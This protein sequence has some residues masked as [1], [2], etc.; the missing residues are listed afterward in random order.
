MYDL[1]L[2]SSDLSPKSIRG[3]PGSIFVPAPE[4]QTIFQLDISESPVKIEKAVSEEIPSLNH[5]AVSPNLLWVV[6]DDGLSIVN[7]T[8]LS[9]QRDVLETEF[10]WSSVVSVASYE[11]FG[12]NLYLLT[13]V[14][15]QIFKI[16]YIE[17]EFSDP[18]SWLVE[19]TDLSEAVDFAIDGEIYILFKDG[20]VLKFLQG[21]KEDFGLL[22]EDF[23]NPI[24]IYTDD[25]LDHIYILD[26]EK[27]GIIVF[28]KEGLYQSQY[29]YDGEDSVW[30]DVRDLWVD[31]ETET[32]YIL[33]GAKV[34][35]ISL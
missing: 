21:E 31:S 16:S 27:K 35:R 13:P 10:A 30:E 33:A 6:E 19:E 7:R 3:A 20:A 32:I 29:L 11:A 5:L 34:F 25:T 9:L 28:T 23:V 1:S 12:E 24:A 14:K 26:R 4:M 8:D 22:Y 15:N 18:T 2:Q 17:G